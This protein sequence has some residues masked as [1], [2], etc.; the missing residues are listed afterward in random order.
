MSDKGSE[1]APEDDRDLDQLSEIDEDQFEDY[2]PETA[3]IEDRPVE[4]DEDVART[5]KAARRQRTDAERPRKVKEGRRDKK[6]RSRDG[7]T[8]ADG[9][10]D[11]A[12]PRKSRRSEVGGS[13]PIS[14]RTSPEPQLED[15]SHLTPE[16]RRRRALDRALD[17]AVKG[18]SKRKKKKDEAV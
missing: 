16:E 15:D 12:R 14:K 4:I 1:S 5:L 9:Q 8:D 13:R 17:A 6:K 2:D 10:D 7:D 3:N 18:P 11:D